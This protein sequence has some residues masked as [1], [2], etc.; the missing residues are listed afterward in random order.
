MRHI[1]VKLVVEGEA[2]GY[3]N[4]HKEPLN[5]RQMEA[6]NKHSHNAD[7]NSLEDAYSYLYDE[8]EKDSVS[9]AEDADTP[10]P[11]QAAVSILGDSPERP[12][13]R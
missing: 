1:R 12:W 8:D 4:S 7:L 13:I 9:S 11:V 2:L 3:S 6:M 5:Y 10:M